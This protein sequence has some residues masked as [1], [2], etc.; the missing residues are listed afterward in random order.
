MDQ[1]DVEGVLALASARRER[2]GGFVSGGLRH[3]S[4]TGDET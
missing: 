3:G 4:P 2:D 1:G